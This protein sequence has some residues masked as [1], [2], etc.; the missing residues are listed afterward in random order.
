MLILFLI[1]AMSLMAV[2]LIIAEPMSTHTRFKFK[3]GLMLIMAGDVAVALCG[4]YGA[5]SRFE[6]LAVTLVLL[7]IAV[8]IYSDRRVLEHNSEPI[9]IN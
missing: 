4:L 1:A 8:W 6:L 7:G 9:T 3:I 5:F 2:C